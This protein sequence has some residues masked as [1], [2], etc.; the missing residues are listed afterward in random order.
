MGQVGKG[1]LCSPAELEA[2]GKPL[3][4]PKGGYNITFRFGVKQDAELRA[5]GDLEHGLTNTDFAAHTP[6]QL[7]S[8]DHLAQLCRRSCGSSRDGALIKADH[9]GSGIHAVPPFPG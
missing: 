4:S 8:W 9:E 6:I 5:F 3:G 1:W 7:V 2:S